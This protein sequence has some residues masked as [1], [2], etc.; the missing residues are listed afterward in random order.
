MNELKTLMR[1]A[2]VSFALLT[3]I[4]GV[5]Y[6]LAIT[7]IAQV[8]MPTQANG[9][10]VVH[11]GRVIGSRLIGQSF[12]NPKYF[13]GRPSATPTF[14]YNAQASGGSNLGPSNPDW[15]KTV[16]ERIQALHAA[17]AQATGPVPME[18]ATASA[19]G[20][21][22]DISPEAALWQASRVA[23]AR[24]VPLAAVRRLVMTQVHAPL[25]GI[26][27]LPRVNVLQLNL[28]LDEMSKR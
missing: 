25:Q 15:V 18:L 7:G 24:H 2:L 14:P 27:G 16:K 28:L 5:L 4:T 10:L 8:A 13:W 17:N 1:P 6:P 11:H 26:L 22:P 9:S 23:A 3:V 20:L 21:D 19:S 12:T